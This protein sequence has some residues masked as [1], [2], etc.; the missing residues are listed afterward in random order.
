M[1]IFRRPH[2]EYLT[3]ITTDVHYELECVLEH[4]LLNCC[5]SGADSKQE[6]FKA[7]HNLTDLA[8][9]TLLLCTSLLLKSLPLPHLTVTKKPPDSN[10]FENFSP[11][12]LEILSTILQHLVHLITRTHYTQGERNDNPKKRNSITQARDDL[13]QT[14]TDKAL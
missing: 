4:E 10:P 1:H 13:A 12:T 11:S 14:F 2:P 9:P 3:L 8:L 7:L 5:F 6:L